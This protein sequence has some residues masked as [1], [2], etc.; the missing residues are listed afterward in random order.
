MG[1]QADLTTASDRHRSRSRPVMLRRLTSRRVAAVVCWTP[2]V[3]CGAWAFIR[4]LG[5]EAGFPL[6]SLISFTPYVLPV[7]LIAVGVS[8]ALQQLRPLVVTAVAALALF[9][10][11][12]P[13]VFGAKSSDSGTPLRVMSANMLHGNGDAEQLLGLVRTRR[14]EV[15]TVQ[16]LT[17]PLARR[18]AALGIREQLPHAV[19]APQKGVIGTGIY[20]RFPARPAEVERHGFLQARALI[21]GPAGSELDVASVHPVPPTSP[22]AVGSWERGLKALPHPGQEPGTTLLLGDFNATLDHAEFR[23][24]LDHGYADAGERVGE[25]LIPTWPAVDKPFWFLPVTIDHLVF[26]RELGVRDY[27]VIDI[28]G[29][30]HRALYGELVLPR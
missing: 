12:A 16:E 22:T 26:E 21:A 25:G 29:T 28:G 4:V 6:V 27:E 30:D 2:A 1:R 8:A 10:V 17:P 15:L 7:A 20:S 13:R 23:D 11:L 18:L 9:S 24:L 3:L 5:L 19:L 14:V